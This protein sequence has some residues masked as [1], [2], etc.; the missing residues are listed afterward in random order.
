MVGTRT[1][2]GDVYRN[3]DGK[4]WYISAEVTSIKLKKNKEIRDFTHDD[5]NILDIGY[6]VFGMNMFRE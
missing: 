1:K 4:N 5:E 6:N 2:S 3:G